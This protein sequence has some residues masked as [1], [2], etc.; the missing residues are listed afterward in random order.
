MIGRSASVW[1]QGLS[2]TSARRAASVGTSVLTGLQTLGYTFYIWSSRVLHTF[3]D[4]LADIV[5]NAAVCA[6]QTTLA[7]SHPNAGCSHCSCVPPQAMPWKKLSAEEMRLAKMWY[8]EDKM[9]PKEIA[10]LLRRSKSTLT[11]FLVQRAP[12]KR[13]ARKPALTAARIDALTGK[14]NDLVKKANGKYEVT[15][16]MLRRCAREK[17]CCRTILNVLHERK[18]YFRPFR[19]KPVLT[20]KDVADRLAFAKKY[21][22]RP[23]AWWTSFVHMHIDV[24]HF[25][26]PPRSVSNLYS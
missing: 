10:K 18:V 26:V 4:A 12:R 6:S 22:P 1:V 9:T 19:S 16:A 3:V 17:A 11:R 24:K 5:S 13:Q 7:L 2:H 15:V 8:K 25:Q 14:L 23:R 20:D 21:A